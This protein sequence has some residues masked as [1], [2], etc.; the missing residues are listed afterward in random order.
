MAFYDEM[1]TVA[2]ELLNEFKQGAI[3]YVQIVPGAGP[4]DEPGPSTEVVT[5]VDA[6]ARGVS[7]KYVQSGLALASD[8]TVTIAYNAAVTPNMR[9]FIEIDGVRY[10]IIQDIST[11]AAG[12]R[13]VW[14]FIVRKGA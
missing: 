13:V 14:K 12:T 11:P 6:V 2:S 4:I 1:Q 10:K 5:D 9:D 8:L 7:F 3:K